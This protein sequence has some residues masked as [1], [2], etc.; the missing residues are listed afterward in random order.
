M[1][2]EVTKLEYEQFYFRY[3]GYK[4][5]KSIAL[6]VLLSVFLGIIFCG[7]SFDWE[8]MIAATSMSLIF[9][10]SILFVLPYVQSL[11]RINRVIKANPG[12][13]DKSKLSI[14]DDGLQIESSI[15][16][17][18]VLWVQI[19]SVNTFKQYV[20][21]YFKNRVELLIPSRAFNSNAEVKD[22]VDTIRIEVS[23]S[24]ILSTDSLTEKPNY[25]Q[26][27]FCL[28]PIIGFFLGIMFV[29]LGIFKYKDKWLILI[30]LFGIMFTPILYDTLFP[31]LWNAGLR[32]EKNIEMVRGNM[33]NLIKDIEF[34]KIQ[35]GVYPKSLDKIDNPLIYDLFQSDKKGSIPY[36]YRV[37]G[38]KYLLFSSGIDKMPN[39]VDD[40]YPDIATDDSKIGLIRESND[41]INSFQNLRKKTKLK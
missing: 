20:I 5:K 33:N 29:I 37:I 16:V 2:F 32:E 30:G 17:I 31:E 6:I 35:Y 15:E 19:V 14:T 12:F 22:F 40:I 25:K 38:D 8:K 27:F 3:H 4:L 34:Y 24:K 7:S 41:S 18:K 39:T 28:I 23:K 11:L 26:G 36:N 1:E 21:L 9:L 13:L 10:I